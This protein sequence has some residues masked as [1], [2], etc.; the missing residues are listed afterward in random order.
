MSGQP[1][2]PGRDGSLALCTRARRIV[3]NT[4]AMARE[5]RA[6]AKGCMIIRRGELN[7]AVSKLLIS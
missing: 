2:G 7:I 5:P 1:L 4:I 6:I 3:I